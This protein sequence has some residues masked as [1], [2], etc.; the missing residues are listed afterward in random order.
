MLVSVSCLWL[1]LSLADALS[2][3][4]LH[5]SLVGAGTDLHVRGPEGEVV[6]QQLHDEC[7][8][9]VGLLTQGVELCDGLVE[10]LHPH[11]RSEC[12]Q[13]AASDLSEAM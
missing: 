5:K 7:A 11:H 8:V 4:V 9:L 12:S 6:T 2:A 1:C 3:S 13:L 10:G